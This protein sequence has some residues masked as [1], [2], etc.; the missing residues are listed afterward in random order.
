MPH[1][2][3]G[4]IHAY[5]DGALGAYPEDEATRIR[6]HLEECHECAEALAE[7]RDLRRVASEIL[8]ATA[9]APVDLD[10]FEELVAQA[11]EAEPSRPAG[12]ASRFRVL[13]M[14][15]T[16]VVS[17][18][19]GWLARDLTTPARDLATGPTL[20]AVRAQDAVASRTNEDV[21][22]EEDE[23]DAAA[24][25]NR[26]EVTAEDESVERQAA[27]SDFAIQ[28]QAPEES[29]DF[30][31]P[32]AAQMAPA[33]APSRPA[34]QAEVG[35]RDVV[36]GEL[37]LDRQRELERQAEP[38]QARRRLEAIA[39]AGVAG[40][41]DNRAAGA[42]A[43]EVAPTALADELSKTDPQDLFANEANAEAFDDMSITART[44]S[45][46]IPGLPVRDVRLS[47]LTEGLEP[48]V[49]VI[50]ELPDGRT[51]ELRFVAV[52]RGG[53]A[54]DAA[55]ARKASKGVPS[56]RE[57]EERD[58]LEEAQWLFAESIPEGWS[59]VGRA[60]QGGVAILRGPLSEAELSALL[61]EA[62][63]G[64]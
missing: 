58:A 15:A 45:F 41:A 54:D 36:G 4:D 35:R 51:L 13:R 8:A 64:R 6:A 27:V 50:Q 9:Q 48:S 44:S 56:G 49:T 39:P 63:A 22:Q 52:A 31:A 29:R 11:G 1:V 7:E 32:A 16:V 17:L 5:L 55:S 26:L 3:K 61:D 30:D 38:A 33:A 40:A 21:A 37:R 34:E 25:L 60:V 46:V 62:V 42:P 47:A 24:S 43:R 10:P 23:P 2:S 28:P 57:L 12:G 19:A 14:A 53:A 20:D 18:G 59:Q